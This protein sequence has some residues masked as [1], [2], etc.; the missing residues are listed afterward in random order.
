MRK[1]IL[2][3]ILALIF[4]GDLVAQSS[5]QGQGSVTNI[6]NT[7]V[8]RDPSGDIVASTIN[9]ETGY[10]INSVALA[11]L[12]NI[13]W[14]DINFSAVTSTGSINRPYSTISDAITASASGDLILVVPGVYSEHLAITQDSISIVAIGGPE[15]TFLEALSSG[16]TGIALTDYTLIKGFTLTSDAAGAIIELNAGEN[17]VQILDNVINTTGSAT[18]GI[19]VGAAGSDSLLVQ[20]NT[21]KTNSGDGAIWL[22]KTNTN[23]IVDNNYFFGADSTS[24]YA[25]QT[26][27]INV[28]RFSNNVIEGYASGIFPHTVTA[29]SGGSYNIVIEG[30]SIKHTAKAIRLGHASQT[31]NMDS[32]FVFNNTIYEN[33]IGIYIADDAT[34]L[35]NTFAIVDNRLLEN[36]TNYNNAHSSLVPYALSNWYGAN[37]ATTGTFG[38]ANTTLDGW[39]LFNDPGTSANS[40][41]AQWVADNSGTQQTSSVQTIFGANPYFRLSAPNDSGTETPVLELHDESIT[42]FNGAAGVD[43][44]LNFNGEDN[45]GIITYMEDEDR[46]DFDNDVDV[47]GALT[48][49]SLGTGDITISDVTPVLN[50]KDTDA[51]AGDVNFSIQADATD[52]G[53]GTEDIDVLFN[54]QVAGSA[55]GFM[56]F[57]A[58][59]DFFLRSGGGANTQLVLDSGGN[60]GIGTATPGTTLE[61]SDNTANAAHPFI[62]LLN[63]D[64]Q[65]TGETSQTVDVLFEFKGTVDSGS[66]YT[67]EEAAKISAYKIG[68]FWT[69]GGQADNDAGL[70][71]YTVTN[72]AYVLNS[73]FS[74]NALAVVGN[75]AGATYGSNSSVLDAEL[76][77][78]NTLS[79]NAQTQ[80]TNNAALVDT[81]DKIIA[82]I[83]ASPSTQ[84]GVP[85]GGIGV[86]TLNDGGLLVGAGTAAVEVL[87]DG[88]TTQILVGGGSN[89]NP[90]WGADIPTAVTIGSG[91]I[92]RVSGTDVADADVV[93]DITLATSSEA[94][95]LN[96]AAAAT[97]GAVGTDADVVLAFDA[98][99][100]QGSITYMEDEDRFDF[101]NDII[102]TGNIGIGLTPTANMLGLSVEDGLITIKETTTPTADADYGKIYN[103]SDNIL[104]FQDGDGNE[105]PLTIG[106]NFYGEMYFNANGNPTTIETAATPIAMR[107]FTTGLLSDWTYTQGSTGAVIAYYDRGANVGVHDDTHGLSTGDVIS[108]RGTTDYNGVFSVTVVDADSFYIADTWNNDNGASDWDEGDYLTAGTGAGGVYLID[109]EFSA[110]EG[111]GA[112]STFTYSLFNG[113]TPLN[114]TIIQRKFANNDVGAFGGHSLITVSDT[115]RMFMT[116]QSTGTNAVTHSYGSIILEK[117]HD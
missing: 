106:G 15:V 28:A 92:Y 109:W 16:G 83:N 26:A 56:S 10:E 49:G 29:G 48:I 65:A 95:F 17:S 75:V 31:V 2:I 108:I 73:T 84:I 34:V 66:N 114:N 4:A 55:I 1:L 112:G 110:S 19:S 51:S 5:V 47:A 116:T 14:V 46:F 81:D 89:V 90:A 62:T 71:L 68:D 40:F 117:I 72:G 98:V 44:F 58:D 60:V 100:N 25:I 27:G 53:D 74:D 105:H 79:S 6:Y 59:G 32:V 36:T 33:N 101:D 70:K 12:D 45:D 107:E 18:F 52:I 96:N 54:A 104:Y 57:D 94:N 86:G 80:I 23:T 61:L 37:L 113:A 93:D 97:F 20:G 69:A 99:T 85:A 41:I 91:Y 30:N 82:I 24:G 9:A 3:L 11:S 38:A 63:D 13:L 102:V 22:Q 8:R 50:Y 103:K 115:D 7:I 111:G 43:Y 67:E 42:L 88:L 77:Y 87:A 39:L 76:L 21:F 78:I 35:A 64:E